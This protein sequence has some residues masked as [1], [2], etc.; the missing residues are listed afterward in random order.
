MPPSTVGPTRSAW[1]ECIQL[2]EQTN[3]DIVAI[4]PI[5]AHHQKSWT[6]QGSKSPW[7]GTDLLKRMPRARVLLY[8]H[9]QL[10]ERDK[11]DILG[12]RLLNRLLEQ[13][14]H[15]SSR[16]PIFFLCHSTGGLVAKACLA[17]ASRAEPNQAILTSCHGIA[18]FA[19]PHQGSTYLSAE[20][21][22]RSIRRLLYLEYEIPLAL[23][24]QFRPRQDRLWH[25]SNQFKA[26]SADMKVWSFLETLDSTLHVQDLES[27]TIIEF[28]APITSIRSGLLSIE[29]ENEIPMGT[30][31]AGTSC[32]EGQEPAL[33]AFL[34]ELNDSV[35]VA[36]ELSKRMDHPLQVEQRVMVQVN[37]FFEDTALGVSDETPLKLW[38]TQVSL[39]KYLAHGPS[40]CLRERLERIQPGTLDDSSL[41]S[42]GSRFPSPK[43]VQG[44]EDHEHE[45]SIDGDLTDDDNNDHN[46]HDVHNNH[47]AV[48]ESDDRPSR[49]TLKH[50]QSYQT[51]I[52]PTLHS[53]TIHIT[54][55]ATDGYFDRP[56]S[57]S[58][59][60]PLERRAKET[61]AHALGI[62]H[63]R[64]H[65]RNISDDSSHA[66]SSRP[67]SS[68]ASPSR[69][70]DFLTIPASTRD[71]IN[72]N[73]EGADIPRS[74]P[75]FDRPDP[76]TEKL[77]WIHVPYTHTGW[78][79]Q[80]IRRAC[81]DRQ[82]PTFVRKF[83][84]DENWYLNLNRARH[85]EPHARFV[86]PKC[87]HSR[88]MDVSHGAKEGDAEDPQLALYTPYL[89]W[90][91][92]RNLIQRRKVI[93]DRLHQGRSRPVPSRI[94]R[95]SL[96]AQLIWQYMGCEPPIHFRRTLDQ[97]GY[98]NLRSTVAR[99]DDQMLWKR[100][101]KPARIDDQ[102]REYLEATNDDPEGT[103][104]T[105]FMDGNV[106]MVDQLWL[107]I[108]DRK[109]IVTFFPNQE[110]TTSEGKLLE[111]TN[112]HS[113]IYNE[114]NGD[115]ARRFETAGDLAALIM[116]HATTVLLDRTLH[117]DLQVLRIFEESISILTESVTKSFKRF[118]NRGFFSRPADFDRTTEGKNMTAAELDARDRQTARRNRDDLSVLL[119]LRDIEDELSTILKLLDQQDTVIKSMMKYFDPS[120]CGI[121]F[122]DAAQMR[123]DEYRTQIGEMKENSHLAQKAVET[124]LDLKQKQANVDEAKMARWQAEETQNQS[125]S[126]MVFTIFTVIFLPLSFFTSLFGIN[127]R[128]WSGTPE[129]LSL[130]QMFEI[131]APASFA[132]IGIALLM[133]F[134]GSLRQTV[135]ESHKIGRGLLREFVT[136]PIKMFLHWD[137]F[138]S[139][140]PSVVPAEDSA[141]RK[142]F[143]QYL[144]YSHNRTQFEEDF[145]QRRQVERS[146]LEELERRKRKR[147]KSMSKANGWGEALAEKV[148]RVSEGG[149]N[150]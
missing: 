75:R 25:L 119:E 48:R 55:A 120:G 131:G 14:K 61:I 113:S 92:Y 73:A 4:P 142:R 84:N 148:R 8:S 134:S 87:I 83:I 54:K 35:N 34:I 103:E 138:R 117:R 51:H 130:A 16:R 74:L 5:G 19:T 116:L 112:L 106:L 45:D 65:K 27:N 108:V 100:T 107:W 49:P 135:T 129:N 137:S 150:V 22:Q 82:E 132:I 126:L 145:W 77:V 91:T 124:L 136:T 13:R 10:R 38:S 62:G 88:Q 86:R 6:A 140:I 123:I 39:E 66:S 102:L 20:E 26:L 36:V 69:Q 78:V 109:T 15:D 101:R 80:V 143:D 104:P 128:E 40:A 118:R 28:H 17:L 31:H 57:E 12:Q 110:A 114:L 43:V 18:F 64:S 115:L 121:V 68:S 29:H 147:V 139:K 90:D 95:S 32:F 50:G 33:E 60:P 85:K 127:A 76:G 41:S 67:N 47:E 93:E 59:P 1:F 99:D 125:R 21:Y 63:V 111:Q 81:Q 141:M 56:S 79:S 53:P 9:G 149:L 133:A 71:R 52:D 23:R 122:L 42:Y 44:P 146:P 70:A 11:I 37:G 94:D 24:E 96:E 72:Q 58:P 46:D 3:V 89:H 97:F 98:P 105:E 144:G 30:D 2:A 7:L